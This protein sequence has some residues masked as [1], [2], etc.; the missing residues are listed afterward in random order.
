MA[1]LLPWYLAGGTEMTLYEAWD[2]RDWAVI[3]TTH[4]QC[5]SRALLQY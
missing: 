1:Y 5:R 3:Q 4:L 2:S